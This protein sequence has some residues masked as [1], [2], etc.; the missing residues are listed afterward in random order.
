MFCIIFAN[1]KVLNKSKRTKTDCY[2]QLLMSSFELLHFF[3]AAS[4]IGA[5]T[6]LILQSIIFFKG[7]II[8][9]PLENVS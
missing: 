8:I 1:H 4:G 6:S 5:V 9:D 2:C 7:I 3:Q